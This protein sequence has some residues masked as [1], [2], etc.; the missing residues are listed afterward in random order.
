[1]LRSVNA[2]ALGDTRIELCGFGPIAAAARTAFLIGEWQPE[3]V[4]LIGV[5]GGIPAH[6]QLSQAYVFDE[7]VCYG[8]GAG[9]G[10]AFQSAQVMGWLQWPTLQIGDRLALRVGAALAKQIAGVLLSSTTAS[11]SADEVRAKAVTCGDFAAEDME[12]FSVAL[13]CAL[14]SRPLTIV[15]GISNCVGDRDHSRWRFQ[16]AMVSASQLA[17]QLLQD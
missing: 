1:M 15:R 11:A 14:Q 2:P 10:A 12:G 13:A 9:T 17:F 16:D 6:T 8:V 4:F 7:V 5:A 3:N